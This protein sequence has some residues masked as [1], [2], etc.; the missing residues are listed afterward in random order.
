MGR[1]YDARAVYC[2]NCGWNTTRRRDEDDGT[3][4]ACNR[5]HFTMQLMGRNRDRR[6]AVAK[7]D[8]QRI[9]KGDGP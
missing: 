9:R 2:P 7:A 4:G 8:F 5:C 1:A 6:A 3:Y